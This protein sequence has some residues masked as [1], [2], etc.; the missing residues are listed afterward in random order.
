ML[1][2]LH[3]YN[4]TL[5]YCFDSPDDGEVGCRVMEVSKQVC[6]L[7]LH[8]KKKNY[9]KSLT[10]STIQSS[11]YLCMLSSGWIVPHL[12]IEFRKNAAHV[13]KHIAYLWLIRCILVFELHPGIED[14][15]LAPIGIIPRDTDPT[16]TLQWLDWL[17][18]IQCGTEN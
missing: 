14:L 15:Q 9:I 13:I 10:S 8:I 3:S 6:T 1:P 18:H 16:S 12:Y 11:V 17:L 2:H 4:V 5:K 7:T